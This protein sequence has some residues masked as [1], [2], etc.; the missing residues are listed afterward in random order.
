MNNDGTH[1]RVGI[2]GASGYTGA[3]LLRLLAGHPSFELVVATGDSMAGTPIADLYPSLAAYYGDRVF[4]AYSPEIVRGL[5][6]VFCGLPHGVSMSVIPDMRGTVGHIVDLG[7]DFRLHDAGLYPTWYGAEHSH[8]AL[9][10]DFVYGLP[11]LFRSE[12]QGAELIAATGC[13]A[14]SAVFGLA[15]LVKGGLIEPTGLVADIKSGVSGAGRPP[16]PHTTFCTVDGDTTAYGL[17]THRHTPE[18]EQAIEDYSGVKSSVFFTPHLV[19]MSRGILATCYGMAAGDVT[20]DDVLGCL[21][22]TYVDSPWM[23]VSERSPSTK[24]TLGA[25]TV[26]L[27]ARVDQRTGRVLVIAALDN[28]MKGASGMAVQNANLALGLPETTGL[29]IVGVYP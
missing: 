26:H 12:L 8:P 17:L 18:I 20:S 9:L 15:P 14:A 19:P 1:F 7:S 10:D 28:L 4:D 25:N 11:E 29:P 24:A 3:E 21:R 6:L 5:D 13:N 2:V 27:T 22:D 23:V 16:K